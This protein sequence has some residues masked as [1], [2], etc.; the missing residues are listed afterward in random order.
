M[1][2]DNNNPDDDEDGIDLNNKIKDLEKNLEEWLQLRQETVMC[3]F[4]KFFC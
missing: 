1:Q 2:G 3:D 4:T